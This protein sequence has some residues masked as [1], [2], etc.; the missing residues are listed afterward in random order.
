MQ[1]LQQAPDQDE[2]PGPVEMTT[3]VL[4][5]AGVLVAVL[6]PVW[7]SLAVVAWVSR[8]SF[9]E[10]SPTMWLLW[11]LGWVPLA[12]ADVVGTM[13]AAPLAALAGGHR[14]VLLG[15]R[16]AVSNLLQLGWWSLVVDQAWGAVL[17][18]GLCSLLSTALDSLLPERLDP[19]A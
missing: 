13:V 16:A 12:F 5:L 10:L 18:W 3:S 7:I 2:T 6:L 14:W 9:V 15:T 8:F 19:A 17:A 1:Q 4:W 11:V